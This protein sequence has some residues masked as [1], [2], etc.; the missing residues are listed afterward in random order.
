MQPYYDYMKKAILETIEAST[1]EKMLQF[2][3]TILMASTT[4]KAD[5]EAFE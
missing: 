3:Y 4:S 1:D 2:I 5:Q